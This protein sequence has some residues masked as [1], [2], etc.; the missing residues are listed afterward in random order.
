MFTVFNILMVMK[1][2]YHF[3]SDFGHRYL[4]K[5]SADDQLLAID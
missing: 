4:T 5:S 1:K 3:I 2:E